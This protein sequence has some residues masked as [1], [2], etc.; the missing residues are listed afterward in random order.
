MSVPTVRPA[1]SAVWQTALHDVVWHNHERYGVIRIQG[2]DRISLLQ[3]TTTNDLSG[4]EPGRGRQTVLVTEEATCIDVLT[5]LADQHQCLVLT[6]RSMIGTV[7]DKLQKNSTHLDV[8]LNDVSAEWE[9]IAI[10][11][12]LAPQVIFQLLG[13]DV[14]TLRQWQWCM[15]PDS[16]GA[17]IIR[18][19]G[20][21][22]LN[23]VIMCGAS[24]QNGIRAT[25]I[26]AAS[27][28]P[29]LPAEEY[30]FHRICAG[31]GTNNVEISP[32]YYPIEAGLLHLT[33]FSKRG[34]TGEQYISAHNS[35]SDVAH[36]LMVVLGTGLAQDAGLFADGA[37][38]GRITS[39]VQVPDKP[40]SKV[41]LAYV[42]QEY[43]IPGSHL[44][45]HHNQDNGNGNV[46]DL[47]TI[48]VD[49][50]CL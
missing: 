4:M 48:P 30:H 18:M 38:V 12:Q 44:T 11:G 45:L 41:G 2:P 37:Q 46:V 19:P 28:I 43:A 40:E 24:V 36:R 26:G 29:F 35:I 42:L 33:S 8:Q 31:I 27:D 1:T 34:Y 23:Y 6:T 20:G 14:H 15:V 7:L 10:A 39:V 50:I 32:D 25:L 49:P 9:S 16:P 47:L 3:N 13:A 5:V 17:F 21:A 22:N